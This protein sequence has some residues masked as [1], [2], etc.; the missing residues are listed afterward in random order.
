MAE[1]KDFISTLQVAAPCSA[2]W[3]RMRGDERARYCEQCR[4]Q[5]YNLSDM[6]RPE[7]EALVREKDGR[8]CVRFYRRRDGTVLLDNCPVG[9]RRARRA[10]ALR[11]SW[12][13]AFLGTSAVAATLARF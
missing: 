6:S 11:L 12:L 1:P 8:L 5:V 2:S 9:L 4:K 7:A 3:D 10:V 13:A